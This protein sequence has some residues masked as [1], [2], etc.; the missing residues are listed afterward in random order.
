MSRSPIALDCW[1]PGENS[2]I[3][4]QQ[5]VIAEVDSSNLDEHLKLPAEHA[6]YARIADH[7]D[8]NFQHF[9]KLTDQLQAQGM[10]GDFTAEHAEL[11][12]GHA[13][14][15]E[16]VQFLHDYPIL[17]SIEI[18]RRTHPGRWDTR[19]EI[20]NYVRGSLDDTVSGLDTAKRKNT[21]HYKIKGLGAGDSEHPT[22]E[23]KRVI[24][25]HFG[26]QVLTLVRNSLL[27]DMQSRDVPGGVREYIAQER[28]KLRSR[29]VDDSE[30]NYDGHSS[31]L[32]KK[33]DDHMIHREMG[34]KPT[35]VI[36]LLSTYYAAFSS[37]I[38][39]D[40]LVFEEESAAVTPDVR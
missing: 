23:R 8:D 12:A 21:A 2:Y 4:A 30:Y 3:A 26:G 39:A 11:V 10:L 5:T 22:I 25:S 6:L 35:W 16:F 37:E 20:D 1:T 28:R 27:I 38:S 31:L 33:L 36:P 24:R 15:A 14:P 7:A 9:A 29:N 40:N 34:E 17:G 32:K 13:T 19:R 18:A